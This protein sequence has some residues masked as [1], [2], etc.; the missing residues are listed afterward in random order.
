MWQARAGENLFVMGYCEPS[1]SKLVANV[2]CLEKYFFWHVHVLGPAY[3]VWPW[4]YRAQH[5]TSRTE[6][7]ID[8]TPGT[9]TA[10]DTYIGYHVTRFEASHWVTGCTWIL[11]CICLTA[12]FFRV[13]LKSREPHVTLMSHRGHLP[14]LIRVSGITW[15]GS[16]NVIL[17]TRYLSTC[18]GAICGRGRETKIKTKAN[19]CG[20]CYY[21][22]MFNVWPV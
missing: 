1:T 6:C 18:V 8:V 22:I 21:S 16:R 17:H 2:P 19:R 3:F 7:N 10:T 11:T 12:R 4:R 14:L 20:A 13:T 5:V 15:R 9:F